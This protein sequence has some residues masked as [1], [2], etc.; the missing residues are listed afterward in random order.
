MSIRIDVDLDKRS[1]RTVNRT[2][3]GCNADVT[4]GCCVM[5]LVGMEY[6]MYG[7]LLDEY[8]LVISKYM[9]GRMP[10]SRARELCWMTLECAAK[11]LK[12]LVGTISVDDSGNVSGEI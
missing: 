10:V 6:G 12:V 2:L 5:V 8:I 1:A 7:I 4:G 9:N 11:I 3:C